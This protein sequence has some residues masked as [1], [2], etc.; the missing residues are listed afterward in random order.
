MIGFLEQ[1]KG[2][3][4]CYLY[5]DMEW[6]NGYVTLADMGCMLFLFNTGC[7]H[8]PT[9][10][11]WSRIHVSVCVKNHSGLSGRFVCFAP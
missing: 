3:N 11:S 1:I 7:T 10:F 5:S 4:K 2:T 9:N 8:C 6:K